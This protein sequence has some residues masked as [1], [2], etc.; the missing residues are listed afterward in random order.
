MAAYILFGIG[1]Q[2][3]LTAVILTAPG[4]LMLSQIFVP[5]TEVPETM[6][7]VKL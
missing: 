4:S 1:A 5:Q 2:H 6:G 3:L 7:A